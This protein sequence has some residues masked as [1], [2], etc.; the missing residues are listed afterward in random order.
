MAGHGGNGFVTVCAAAG[1]WLDA[2]KSSMVDLLLPDLSDDLLPVTLVS[3][4][5]IASST[6]LSV[7]GN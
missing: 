6:H 2:A 4:E 3:F 1:K 7:P 5:M